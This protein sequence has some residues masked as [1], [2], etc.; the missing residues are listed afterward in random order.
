MVS[1]AGAVPAR[2]HRSF[3]SSIC[4]KSP[5]L[6]ADLLSPALDLFRHLF[7]TC[8]PPGMLDTANG[9]KLLRQNA[10]FGNQRHFA[11]REK[12]LT[13]SAGENR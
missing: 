7:S 11:A 2:R 4:R 9:H 13:C 12:Y 10:Y 1:L 5:H 3:S 8:F 6:F